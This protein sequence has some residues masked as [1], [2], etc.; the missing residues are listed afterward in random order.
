MQKKKSNRSLTVMLIDDCEIDLLIHRT[1]ITRCFSDFNIIEFEN[2]VD[3]L[4]FLRNNVNNNKHFR[5]IPDFILLDIFMPEKNGFEFLND[6]KSIGF[7]KM[8]SPEL[9]M[10]TASINPLDKYRCLNNE[11]VKTF[12]VKPLMTEHILKIFGRK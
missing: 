8:R 11:H 12:L 7:P 6:F 4:S 5:V 3:A 2:P 1:L 10:V 9:I